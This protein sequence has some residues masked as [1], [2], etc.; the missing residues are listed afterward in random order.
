MREPIYSRRGRFDLNSLSKSRK[1]ATSL[2]QM[3]THQEA[4][5]QLE[6]IQE[7]AKID[8]FT[9]LALVERLLSD[10]YAIINRADFPSK[11]LSICKIV[12]LVGFEYLKT[13]KKISCDLL[14]WDS[15]ERLVRMFNLWG[16]MLENE[17]ECDEKVEYFMK[18][19]N[20]SEY[21]IEKLYI[22][23]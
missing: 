14:M 17:D 18:R 22:L 9:S 7:L 2:Q 19:F 3:D 12:H 10:F 13:Y 4:L 21:A 15:S 1:T 11:F 23:H 5:H 20:N 16:D 6:Q 8:F